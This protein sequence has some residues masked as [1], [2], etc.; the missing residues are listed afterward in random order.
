MLSK[1]QKAVAHNSMKIV[2]HA[3]MYVT[4]MYSRSTYMYIKLLWKTLC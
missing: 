4:A 3:F 1:T 2:H